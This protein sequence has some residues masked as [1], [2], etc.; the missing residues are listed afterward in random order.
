[1][2]SIGE[3]FLSGFVPS[4]LNYLRKLEKL[5]IDRQGQGNFN[6]VVR[7]LD[8][9]SVG[10]TGSMPS[11]H[12]SPNLQEI[13]MG[14]CYFTGSIPNTF[15]AGKDDYES[16]I[17]VDLSG[18]RITGTLPSA[19]KRFGNLDLNIAGNQISELDESFCYQSGWMNGLVGLYGCDA[20][21]CPKGSYNTYGRQISD[22]GMC[23]PC[24]YISSTVNY[25]SIACVPD[26]TIYTELSILKSFYNS[27]GG[28][29]WKRRT[30][31]MNEKLSVCNWFGVTCN[32]Q[33]K[34]VE[35]TLP[36][37]N[38][39]GTVTPY[40]FILKFMKV[41]NLSDNKIDL[42]LV[43]IGNAISLEEI[44][45][46]RTHISSLRGIDQAQTLKIF[47]S[48]S[49][50]F[51]GVRLPLGLFDLPMLEILEV[52][53]SHFGGSLPTQIGKLTNL[54]ELWW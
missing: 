12:L 5:S 3:N 27:I 50:N 30:N 25:G 18:N 7:D 32:D 53:D 47:R 34:V 24:P 45:V 13:Y 10:F 44:N 6:N 17:T 22:A 49:N 36:S 1:M 33:G 29:S 35:I 23:T 21:A 41:L 52:S 31:W 54:K 9:T 2:S 16:L 46:D 48:R 26:G 20:F 14:Y 40:I 11:L 19:L 39:V 8:S 4:E 38:L 28:S 37:N 51:Y 43:G 42:P 15:L